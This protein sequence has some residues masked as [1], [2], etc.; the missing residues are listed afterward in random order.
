MEDYD[1]NK[2]EDGFIMLREQ[3]KWPED[4]PTLD[5]AV[6]K[7]FQDIRRVM[8]KEDFTKNK[9]RLK[10]VVKEAIKHLPSFFNLDTSDYLSLGNF[11]E[12]G[13]KKLLPKEQFDMLQRQRELKRE[14]GTG[15]NMLD[16]LEQF[17]RMKAWANRDTQHTKQKL[18]DIRQVSHQPL[19]PVAQTENVPTPSLPPVHNVALTQPSSPAPDPAQMQLIQAMTDLTNSF[20]SRPNN[21][22]RNDSFN[23]RRRRQCFCCG[24]PNHG[25][26]QC[27]VFNE[28]LTSTGR[29]LFFQPQYQQMPSSLQ[30]LPSMQLAVSTNFK[31]FERQNPSPVTNTLQT[32]NSFSPPPPA[33]ST[34]SNSEIRRT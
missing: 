6:T 20:A 17:L 14:E 5:R 10:Q 9:H 21:N 26:R 24:D 31:S 4:E 3:L 11:I 7:Y 22:N 23:N 1:S 25:I 34:S 27:P 33:T 13:Q 29:Q 30:Q 16:Q 28:F 18:S 8:S 2:L 15:E 12:A 32:P 19:N